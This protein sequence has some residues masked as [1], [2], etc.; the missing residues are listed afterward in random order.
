M[1]G[2]GDAFR[3]V[4]Q[5]SAEA[6]PGVR[7]WLETPGGWTCLGRGLFLLVAGCVWLVPFFV[8]GWTNRPWRLFP[9]WW[10]FQHAAS[11]LFAERTAVWWDHH[12]EGVLADG[13]CLELPEAELFAQGRLG[14]RTR[15]DRLLNESNRSRMRG[16]IRARLAAYVMEKGKGRVPTS[17]GDASWQTLRWVRALWEVGSPAMASP[18]GAWNP[19]PVMELAAEQRVVLGAYQARRDGLV[20]QVERTVPPKSLIVRP[21]PKPMAGNPRVA[22]AGRA[23]PAPAA[24]PRP[25]PRPVPSIAPRP[26][27][28]LRQPPALTPS[29]QPATP[30]AQ[31]G[32]VTPPSLR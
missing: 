8:V 13:S 2:G 17:K 18:S 4:R 20:T 16:E 10:G 26:V 27:S 29:P 25:P 9:D 30:P 23:T 11:G 5:S 3:Q 12:L 31:R 1:S 7:A 32:V 22:K 14:A 19:P 28:P 15:F 24:N 21:A 6:G